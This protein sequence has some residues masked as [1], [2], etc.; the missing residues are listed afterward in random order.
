MF[1]V[2]R[3]TY[4]N[5]ALVAFIREAVAHG[6][7]WLVLYNEAQD[8]S[9]AKAHLDKLTRD[10]GQPPLARYWSPHDASV[11]AG[12]KPLRPLPL[13]GAPPLDALLCD[14]VL[15]ADLR[16]RAREASLREAHEELRAV[17]AA[18]VAGAAEPARLRARLRDALFTTGAQAALHAVPADILV[19]AFREEL[20]ARS[21]LHRWVR[22][23]F[24]GLAT[25]VSA[26][27]RRVRRSFT[28]EPQRDAAD[29]HR[30][31]DRVLRD[32]LARTL[33]SLAP[34]LAAWTGDAT[35]RRLL[36]RAV[37]EET[38][39]ALQAP[40]PLVVA[41]APKDRDAL[42]AFCRELV[43]AELPGGFAEGAL[44]TVATLVYSVP[45]GAAAVVTV[46]SG[47]FGQDA[48]VWAGTLLST[49]LMERFVD[50]LGT[51]IRRNVSLAWAEQHGRTLAQALE[52]RFFRP[53]LSHLDG[54][55][56]EAS[57]MAARLQ[58]AAE[59]IAQRGR[60]VRQDVPHLVELAL[61]LPALAGE[62]QG[63]RHLAR[64]AARMAE[65]DSQPLRVALVGSTGA[66][67]STLLN[68]LAG[69]TLAE[70]GTERPTS[71][72]AVAYAPQGVGARPP[73]AAGGPRGALPGR[74]GRW[75]G[76]ANSRG[77]A[78]LKQPRCQPRRGGLAGAGGGGRGG[79]G[80][81]PGQRGRG[82]AQRGAPP[83]RQTAGPPPRPQPR[84]LTGAR[85][86]RHTLR[87]G[88][89]GGGGGLG[90][91]GPTARLRGE[92]RSGTRRPRRG[93][94]AGAV[95]GPPP[96]RLGGGGQRRPRPKCRGASRAFS[97]SAWPRASGPRRP[98]RAASTRRWRKGW[99]R[100]HQ[101]LLED[102]RA[103]LALASAQLLWRVRRAA[104]ARL[105]GPAAWGLRLSA[106]SG[107]SLLGGTLL[108]RASL[109][110]GL[111]VAASGAVLDEVQSRTRA[112]ATRA[113]MAGGDEP[114]LEAQAR[115]ALASA[116]TA[117]QA[118]GVEPAAVG[119]PEAEAWAAQLEHVRAAAYRDVEGFGVELAVARWWRW[120]RVLLWPLVQLPLLVL[121][122]DVAFRTVRAYLFGPLLE[123]RFYVN[124]AGL[125][126]PPRG[127]GRPP[128]QPLPRRSGRGRTPRR[129]APLPGG[130][131]GRGGLAAHHTS[132]RPWPSHALPPRPW[133]KKAAG[134]RPLAWAPRLRVRAAAQ[135]RG[136]PTFSA[137]CLGGVQPGALALHRFGGGGEAFG[138]RPAGR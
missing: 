135:A 85:G 26:V 18:A 76:R 116:R 113:R 45:A 110:A 93:G 30:E 120:A 65:L 104:A 46:A 121:A 39:R 101:A 16:R 64:D 91:T 102:F 2:S 38:Q 72:E 112:R 127:R 106:L 70:E 134:A 133:L 9:L 131:R 28:G 5:A 52:A 128:R 79:G 10:V 81:A 117:A 126:P 31:A 13:E 36:E 14:A 44:Q 24:R 56:Q 75:L 71:R 132:A 21:R 53:L 50:A 62:A 4:Q 25:A 1:V 61:G 96:L 12:T 130:P 83:L 19:E 58:A 122:G 37:G 87:P 123:G 57:A 69:A 125:G 124:A 97:A 55:V 11:E 60:P 20:D 105:R 48:A 103:R 111:L 7:P 40:G 86:A 95:G 82:P 47:G 67:K 129:R 29:P 8:V 89:A 63:L 119:L 107:G 118:S 22:T 3:H 73:P 78:G 51:G 68:A 6:R 98:W 77:H 99:P 92:R 42:H 23:P 137:P 34:E 49:P 115:A 80:A 94:L 35:G 109:P 33:E 100:A 84:R 43:R 136:R 138:L 54:Q 32:G 66:G 41:D 27:G 88:R 59:A 15:G 17:Q 114:L 108:A 90:R 74:R